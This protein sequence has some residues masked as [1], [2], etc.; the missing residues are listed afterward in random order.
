[1]KAAGVEVALFNFDAG[2]MPAGDRGL[3]S[4]WERQEQFRQNVPVALDLAQRLG[5]RRL[6]ALVGLRSPS[7]H[8]SDQLRLA[9]ENI[10]WAATQAQ[11]A[12]I[13]ILIEAVNTLENGQY[14]LPHTMDAA[15]FVRATGCE[16]VRLQY[17]VY[18]MQR[19]EGN[20]A[21]TLREYC[22]MIAHVQVADSPGRG[23]PGT[24]EINFPYIFQTLEDLGYSGYIGLEYKPT[25]PTTEKSLDWLPRAARAGD[26]R[27]ADLR[28]NGGGR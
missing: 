10:V 7:R 21:A 25:T 20:L 17:D 8:R 18:H 14:L 9:Q 19:M 23:E 2:N 22:P 13:E 27:V 3:L 16:N 11:K 6:N 5:C 24:G 26:F 15:A 28:L 12:D 4:D 1:V